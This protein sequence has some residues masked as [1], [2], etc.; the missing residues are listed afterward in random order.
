MRR[1]PPRSTL[2]PYTTSSDLLE[3]TKAK[4]PFGPRDGK[5]L[6]DFLAASQGR[7]EEHTTELQSRLPLIFRL[8]FFNETATTEIYTLPL[9][10][11]FRSPR[12][13]EGEGPL[14]PPRWKSP[15]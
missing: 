1:R 12:G 15:E 10:D 3:A 7:S 11:L 6:S 9:H 13:D 8:F 4:A 2:F 14:W 5:A